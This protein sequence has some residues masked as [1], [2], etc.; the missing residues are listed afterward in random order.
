MNSGVIF[1]FDGVIVDSVD[2]LYDAYWEILSDLHI[3][4]ENRNI[5][6]LNGL[7]IY[8]IC[9]EII[10]RNNV[11]IS[12]NELY[13]IYEKKLDAIYKGC[14]EIHIIVALI[15]KLGSEGIKMSVASGCPEKYINKV[16]KRLGVSQYFECVIGA[17]S[18]NNGKPDPEVFITCLN[19]SSFD[20]A[21]VIDDG[22]SG[23]LAALRSGC[24]VIKFDSSISVSNNLYELVSHF[25]KHRIS[26]LGCLKDIKIKHEEST[27][28]LNDDEM[29]KWE[30]LQASGSYN[31]PMLMLDIKST[32]N[33]CHLASIQRDYR[34]YRV[35]NKTDLAL[36]VT[37]VIKNDQGNILIG[38]RSVG[39]FQ[40][41]DKFD[42][43][44]AGSLESG[45]YIQQLNLEWSEETG[46][47]DSVTWSKYSSLFIDHANKVLD[48]VVPGSVPSIE[49]DTCQSDEFDMFVWGNAKNSELMTP[50][51]ETIIKYE[52]AQI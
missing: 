33:L 5:E 14:S 38:K 18:I 40:Y 49:L 32:S 37:G 50:L 34:Y 41:P 20:R 35:K 44:P 10:R 23:V 11:D 3:T 6:H 13:A 52:M 26:Y 28:K 31:A 15:S 39:S 29:S 16:L 25:I 1:D 51:A 42:L 30:S 48:L 24:S 43:I 2:Q 17:E 7:K 36:A 47:D 9:E 46:L 45:N 12:P 22:S 21:L 27:Y 4:V 8:Q 19:G